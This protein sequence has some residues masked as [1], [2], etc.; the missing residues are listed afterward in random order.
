MND[1]IGWLIFAAMIVIIGALV[2]IADVMQNW[3]KEDFDNHY[4]KDKKT[5]KLL[6]H[7]AVNKKRKR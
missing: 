2:H 1:S 5:M 7:L 6:G 4:E 3:R